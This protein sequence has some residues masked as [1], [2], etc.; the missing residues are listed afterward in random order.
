MIG[1]NSN[2]RRSAG[3]SSSSFELEEM[4]IAQLQA[5]LEK[6]EQTARKL[7]E[8]YLHRIDEL[9]RRGPE[10]R[11]VLEINPDAAATADALDAE[12]KAGKV[13]GP[14]HGIPILIKDNLDTADRMTTTAGS[15][16]L[17]GSIARQDAFVVSK[18]REAG[19]VILGKANLSEWANFR[20]TH[21]S[22][23]WSGRGGQVKNPYALDRNPSGSS[24][25]SAGAVAASCCAAAVGTETDGSI[26][27]PSSCCSIVGIKPTVGLVSRSGIIP[28]SRTQDTAGPMARTVEDAAILLGAMAGPDPHDQATSGAEGRAERDYRKF[29]SKDGLKGARIGVM[30]LEAFGIG[31][32]A[33]KVLTQAIDALKSQGAIV[34][35]PVALPEQNKLGDAEL[36][37]LLHEFKA[38][39]NAYLANLG[40][41]ARVQSLDQL[42]AFNEA[43]RDREMP[44]F[45]QELFHQA[46]AKGS[47]ES[48]EYQE[49]L[50]TCRELT[51]RKGIDALVESQ[52]L[53][54][55]AAITTGPPCL[56]DLVNGDANTGGS[57]T[58]A[59][60]AG[61]PSITVPAGYV[62]GLPVGL[63]FFG[64]AFSEPTLL[65]LAYAF[66]QATNVRRPPRFLPTAELPQPG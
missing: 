17:E 15:L 8:A 43:H 65:R 10:L 66:E 50:N 27:S 54:A 49:A 39:I 29:L 45:G 56:I 53:D 40:S 33:E 11:N 4:T 22:S 60:V 52:H 63:S 2:D 21:S 44:Y 57:S 32:A 30:R 20:S 26:V 51:R 59:A 23:G 14:L 9:D 37:V 18:L 1:S 25:G 46:A 31:P 35:D 41:Q 34:I 47:L 12:R 28:I 5:A 61:Y 55:L 16:A 24:S 62:F 3:E 64:P 42:I 6:G 7:V 58:L 38:G 48:R 13:R 19:A 36:K